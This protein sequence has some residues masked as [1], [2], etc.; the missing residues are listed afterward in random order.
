MAYRPCLASELSLAGEASV[1]GVST[2]V[3]L[4]VRE[5]ATRVVI[6]ASSFQ[7]GGAMSDFP[8]SALHSLVVLMFTLPGCASSRRDWLSEP[9]VAKP[10]K[11]VQ[12]TF[13][14]TG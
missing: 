13:I 1:A 4:R 2:K 10:P 7:L 8:T 9:L 12:A 14:V 3:W 5:Y 6:G 11:N